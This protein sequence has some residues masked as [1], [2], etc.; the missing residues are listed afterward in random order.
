MFSLAALAAV[1]AM[2]FVG[3]TSASAGSTQ[4]CKVHTGLLCPAGEARTAIHHV[5]AAGTV[6][7]LLLPPADVLCL[8]V[9][10]ESTALGLAAPQSIH[11]LSYSFTGCGTSSA[12]NNVV[13]TAQ[14]LPLFNLLKTGL[15]EGV[16]TA[17]NG[18]VRV[19]VASL[20]L[21]CVYDLEGLESAVGGG[22]QT[23]DETPVTELGGKFFC[24]DEGKV[25]WLLE[26]LDPEH[27]LG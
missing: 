8:N 1:T 23:A 19:Q 5:L 4:I 9:L 18:R 21:D 27:I 20:G 11:T 3:A 12:H 13:V 25:H 24:G 6:A 15:D 7:R 17:T 14:E 16:E 2:A 10:I 26:A 22:H